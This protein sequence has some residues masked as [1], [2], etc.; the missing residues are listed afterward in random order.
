MTIYQ[1]E[2]FGPVLV[3][4]ARGNARRGDRSGQREALWQWHGHL[5]ASGGAARRFQHEIEVGMVG[6]NVPIPVPMAF[7][8]FGGWKNRCSATCTSTDRKA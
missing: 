5:H 2:I 1:D 6:I 8:S 7:F 4:R 3:V